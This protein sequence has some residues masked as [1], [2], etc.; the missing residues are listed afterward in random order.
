MKRFE[1]KSAA[2]AATL[3]AMGAYA[4]GAFAHTQGG[5]LGGSAAA[6]DYYQVTC[7]ND[8]SGAPLS[9]EAQIADNSGNGSRAIALIQKGNLASNATDA[10]EG[11]GIAAYGAFVFVNGGAGVYNL[12]VA[13]T[14]AAADTYQ[15]QFHCMTGNNG[16]G[17]HTGT[18]VS[19][20]Q[21]Q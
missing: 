1:M 12:S 9:L 7:S 10:T 16:T 6:V 17:V 11:D 4:G 21:N 15:V 19:N 2:A 20:K 14:A 5:G 13:H 8:G 3:L 18:A